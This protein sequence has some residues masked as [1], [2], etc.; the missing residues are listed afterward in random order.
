MLSTWMGCKYHQT[1]VLCIFSNMLSQVP[2]NLSTASYYFEIAANL[3][4]PDAQN[5]LAFCYAH[6]H[7]VKKDVYKAAMYYRMAD[8]QG[9]GIIGNSW[10]W[11]DKYSIV[12]DVNWEGRPE[13]H[14]EKY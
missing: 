14:L 2:K 9:H 1:I 4:D 11:K 3:G 7:G 12:D 6:G 13:K 5:D 10:I 8:R